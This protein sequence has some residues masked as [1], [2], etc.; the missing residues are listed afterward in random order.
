MNAR[1]QAKQLALF[2]CDLPEWQSLSHQARQ[3]V[4]DVLSEMLINALEQHCL[5]PFTTYNP[6]DE[7]VSQN[8]T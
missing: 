4:L 5:E 7:H 8:Q 2:E 3:S 6:E 1:K